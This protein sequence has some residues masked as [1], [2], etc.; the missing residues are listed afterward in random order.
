M[1]YTKQVKGRTFGNG[2]KKRVNEMEKM[3]KINHICN[4][5][6]SGNHSLSKTIVNQL[7]VSNKPKNKSD[8]KVKRK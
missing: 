4:T 8:Q 6:T 1:D 7:I 2:L 5:Y 3:N